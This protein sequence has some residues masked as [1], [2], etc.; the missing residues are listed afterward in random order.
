VLSI[1]AVEEAE[2][3]PAVGGVIGGVHVQD[4]D[5]SGAGM[6]FQIKIQQPIGESP[7]VFGGDHILEPG[8]G[9]LGGQGRGII[10]VFLALGNGE[11]ALPHQGQE[12]VFD[13][14]GITGIMKTP[15]GFVGETVAVV[16]FTE[17]QAPGIRGY[18]ATFKIGHNLLG[19][20]AFKDE[21]L[22]ADCFPRV[23]RLRSC[24][25]G[26]FSIL[27]DTLSSFKDVL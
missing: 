12:V 11:P 26:D 10:V 27:A 13:L 19:E 24:L 21:L 25:F 2:L 18:P 1:I 23:S 15:G 20:K 14:A 22:M 7:Q 5:L 4:D 9:G 3:V 17:E 16:Q 8:E 6:G